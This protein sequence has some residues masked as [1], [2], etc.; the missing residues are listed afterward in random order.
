MSDFFGKPDLLLHPD[1]AAV[2]AVLVP[3]SKKHRDLKGES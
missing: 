1:T 3:D 2:S